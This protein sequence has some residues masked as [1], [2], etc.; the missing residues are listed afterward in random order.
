MGNER[1]L[2]SSKLKADDFANYLSRI[3]ETKVTRSDVYNDKKKKIFNP[4][5]IPNSKETRKYLNQIKKLLFP[6]L[7][8]EELLTKKGDFSINGGTIE[9]C[10]FSKRLIF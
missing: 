10:A 7:N 2:S 3:L 9:D 8:I 1:L 5:Q 4:N 6:K